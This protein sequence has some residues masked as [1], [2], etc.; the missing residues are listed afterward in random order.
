MKS[1]LS[2]SS[3]VWRVESA[4]MMHPRL[5]H[6]V[7]LQQSTL[8]SQKH[9]GQTA[10]SH[11][12]VQTGEETVSW[13]HIYSVWVSALWCNHTSRELCCNW[14]CLQVPAD[15]PW[16]KGLATRH[17]GDR[18]YLQTRSSKVKLPADPALRGA[19]CSSNIHLR[20]RKVPLCKKKETLKATILVSFSY[21]VYK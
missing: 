12:R 11:L 3:F 5:H 2:A 7:L 6:W 17:N 1:L 18:L 14:A 13:D 9:P 16:V 10:S 19:L 8:K 15:F 20:K 21:S 4:A